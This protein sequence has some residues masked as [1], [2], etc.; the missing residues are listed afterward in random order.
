MENIF[1]LDLKI[2]DRALKE[3]ILIKQG[4]DWVPQIG[5]LTLAYHPQLR[6]YV[7]IYG[8][9]AENAGFVLLEDFEH[10]WRLRNNA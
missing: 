3:G 2:I 8:S 1:G 9:T 6:R 5:V 10:L 4:N 7:F